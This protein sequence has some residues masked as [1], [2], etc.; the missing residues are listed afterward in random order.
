MF[1]TGVSSTKDADELYILVS[2]CI[3]NGIR[4]FD[5]APSYRTEKILGNTLNRCI[6][7]GIIERKDLFVQTKIDGWQMGELVW[8]MK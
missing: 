1:G 3:K 6:D 2:T 5:T 4:G 7:Q 8:K